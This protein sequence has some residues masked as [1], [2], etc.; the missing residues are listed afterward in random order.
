[1][2]KLL[3]FSDEIE[4]FHQSTP[5]CIPR[6]SLSNVTK[7]DPLVVS[8]MTNIR[9]AL[10]QAT[11]LITQAHDKLNNLIVKMAKD[12]NK[13][14]RSG[15]KIIV[16]QVFPEEIIKV[17]PFQSADEVDAFFDKTRIDYKKS[18]ALLLGY[19]KKLT[20]NCDTKTP[21]VRVMMESLLSKD[22]RRVGSWPRKR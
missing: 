11:N 3:S 2:L 10:D 5:P 9:K 6:L 13:S 1:M 15:S 17:V 22:I 18:R 20:N 4:I 7:L 19:L 21:F 16:P 8:E 12:K 14:K